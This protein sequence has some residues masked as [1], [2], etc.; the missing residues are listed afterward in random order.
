MHIYNIDLLMKIR[1][2]G[3]KFQMIYKLIYVFFYFQIEALQCFLQPNFGFF[4]ENTEVKT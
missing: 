2:W 4:R 1:Y 3:P